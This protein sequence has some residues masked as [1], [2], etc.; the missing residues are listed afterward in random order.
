MTRRNLRLAGY[1][2]NDAKAAS[3]AAAATN[4]ASLARLAPVPAFGSVRFKQPLPLD[5]VKKVLDLCSAR[6]GK[7]QARP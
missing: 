6:P 4:A 2:L 1:I 7:T 3:S 5:I